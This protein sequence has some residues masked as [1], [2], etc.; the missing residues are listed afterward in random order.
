MPANAPDARIGSDKLV[1]AAAAGDA[2]AAFEVA[3]RYADGNRVPKNLARRQ[4]VREGG[5]RGIAVAQYRLEASTNAAG[6]LR[7]TWRRR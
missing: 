6:A 1:R 5:G 7:R 3:A 2:A 4:M